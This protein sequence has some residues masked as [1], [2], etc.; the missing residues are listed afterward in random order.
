MGVLDHR[1]LRFARLLLK[2]YF[3]SYYARVAVVPENMVQ[4]EPDT[5]SGELAWVRAAQ[6]WQAFEER[7][8]PWRESRPI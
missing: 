6:Q 7:G 1:F 5:S 4:A 8:A 3:S 2:P